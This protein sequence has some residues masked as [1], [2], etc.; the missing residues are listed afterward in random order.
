MK[1]IFYIL[2][3][4]LIIPFN[5]QSIDELD[6]L[7]EKLRIEGK[8][9]ESINLNKKAIK[10][11]EKQ[12]ATENLVNAYINLGSL[13]WNL[14]SY[15]ESLLYL[16]RAEN[17]MDKNTNPRV[18]AKLYAIYGRNYTS[19]GLIE[20]SNSNLSR[21]IFHAR[22]IENKKQ[23]ERY[24]YVIYTWKINNFEASQPDSDSINYFQK[25]RL[26]L[27][28]QPLTYVH[29]AEQLLKKKKIDSAEFYLNKASNLHDG[30]RISYQQSMTFVG[31]GKLYTQKKDYE[32][33]ID[34]Y[35]Q[36]LKISEQ[37]NRKDDIKNAYK[38]I[39][40][41][42]KLWGNTE[43][44]NE[45]L[46]K[47]SEI[48]DSIIKSEKEALNIP[49]DKI[50]QEESRKEK[51]QRQKFYILFAST[52]FVLILLLVLLSTKYLKKQKQK[53]EIL[54]ETIH[55]TDE[56]K[57]KLN[58][59]F[60]ELS[61]LASHNDPFFLTRFKEVYP[62]F[63]DRLTSQYPHLTANDIKFC[64]FLRMNLSTKTIAKYKNISVRTIE[65]RK[66]RLR[67]KLNLSSEVDLNKWMMDL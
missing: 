57:S 5:A 21:A 60:D 55:E 14:H 59:A 33:A 53:D 63:Y 56:L 37:L 4:F 22:K 8:I 40:E 51:Q 48:S 67:K 45:Y 23:K 7:T 64:A 13:L 49:I 31:F 42:Y 52:I 54:I 11:Y 47:Y 32:K 50:I 24:L 66:Y 62:D 20:Q 15:K 1:K 2:F 61:K 3:L 17:K 26:E 25:R 10:D 35:L 58:A 19:L 30:Y 16:E 6:S 29:I 18:I 9:K 28:P 65:S 12:D 41:T 44:K 36:S 43:K 46:E 39:S 38:L 34:Y 27:S